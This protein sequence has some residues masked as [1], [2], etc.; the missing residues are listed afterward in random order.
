MERLSGCPQVTVTD[1]LM[2][3]KIFCLLS[4][5]T[6]FAL[7]FSWH[8]LH[9]SSNMINA[10]VNTEKEPAASGFL[11]STEQLT[12]KKSFCSSISGAS[13]D[14]MK[15]LLFQKVRETWCVERV[16]PAFLS[17]HLGGI[18][19][20]PGA[21]GS[22]AAASWDATGHRKQ[23][24]LLV[25]LQTQLVPGQRRGWAT[26]RAPKPAPGPPRPRG[27]IQVAET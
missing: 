4:Q 22:R 20:N 8:R 11:A 26:W 9:L 1:R 24:V 13:A 15:S 3:M 23:K 6:T 27:R 19:R 10:V 16:Y 12:G 5:L 7:V 17:T 21:W 14:L 25:S 18:C 2:A